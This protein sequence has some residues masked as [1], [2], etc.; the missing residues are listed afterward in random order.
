M[1]TSEIINLWKQKAEIDYIPLFISLWLSLNAWMKYNRD[2]NG[3]RCLL[4]FIKD[5]D[6]SLSDKF[7]ELMLASD[8]D[9]NRFRGNFGELHRALDNARIAYDKYDEWRYHIISFTSCPI[10]WN[11]KSS[12]L[13]SV[14]KTKGQRRRITIDDR[15]WVDNDTKRL[16][17][18]YMEILYQIRCILFHGKLAPTPDNERVIK[19][20]YLTLSMI[21]ERV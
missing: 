12:K 2:M 13:E 7:T 19:Q 21:M 17:A 16:F 3:D 20:L 14:V 8:A 6:H 5:N 4:N 11:G 9:G 10:T 18:A 15:L 1:S